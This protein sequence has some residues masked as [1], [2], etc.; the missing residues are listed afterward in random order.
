MKA[1]PA[2][3]AAATFAI[4]SLVSPVS[5]AQG[6]GHADHLMVAPKDLKWGDV[7]SLPPGAKIA[8]IQG[9]MNE[10]KPFTV[11]LK[12]PANYAIPAHSHP[13]IEHVTVIS[14]TF[15]MGTGD[16][17]DPK[18]AQALPP[19]SVAIMQPRTNHFALTKSETIV[20]LHGIGPWGVNY[21]NPADDPRK[22]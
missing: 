16:K 2:A 8:V 9:P 5:W 20:Q 11:R 22:N 10:E 14:G 17:L 1:F 6:Q 3:F 13:G 7:P 19:G 4:A 21:V 12:F 15:H 18:Q